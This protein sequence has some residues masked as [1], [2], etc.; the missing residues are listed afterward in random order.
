LDPNAGFNAHLRRFL[1]RLCATFFQ[2]TCA[3][4]FA[5]ALKNVATSPTQ[6][7]KASRH[8]HSLKRC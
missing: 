3:S 8:W 5:G 6:T 7:A 2:H 4:G 1:Q